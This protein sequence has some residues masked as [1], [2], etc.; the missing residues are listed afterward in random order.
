[1]TISRMNYIARQI[2]NS[3][4]YKTILK[5]G[6]FQKKK[7]LEPVYNPEINEEHW[8]MLLDLSRICKQND[9]ELLLLKT[10]AYGHPITYGGSW[11]QI[12]SDLL[13]ERADADGIVFVDLQ[14]DVDLG[15]DWS[16]DAGAGTQH[17]NYL[18]V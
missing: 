8:T 18:R 5:N 10:P 15:L 14:Y 9:A 13:R 11:T 2:Y 17:L 3:K 12:K 4:G 7:I 1:M 6:S 16:K